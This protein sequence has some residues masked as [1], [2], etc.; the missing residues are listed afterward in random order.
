[1][2]YIKRSKVKIG[3]FCCD[4]TYMLSTYINTASSTS[5]K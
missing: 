3:L 1:M 4:T 5:N 2:K